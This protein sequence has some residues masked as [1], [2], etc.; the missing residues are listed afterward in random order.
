MDLIRLRL[1]TRSTKY[2]R[3]RSWLRLV[4][5]CVWP[6]STSIRSHA[7]QFICDCEQVTSVFAQMEWAACNVC[8]LSPLK[9]CDAYFKQRQ[10]KHYDILLVF[11]FLPTTTTKTK[12][13]PTKWGEKIIIITN[14]SLCAYIS[15]HHLLFI[16]CAVAWA[17]FF[18]I[19]NG[20]AA[21]P[22]K[23]SSWYLNGN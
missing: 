8:I 6:N 10:S 4:R 5:A 3:V 20:L 16:Y 11:L 9:C 7:I 17:L 12:N 15:T 23:N 1:P 18:S 13:G 2:T 22:K 14:R 19:L 21:A